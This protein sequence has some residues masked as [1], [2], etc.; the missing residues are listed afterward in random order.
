[1]QRR[2]FITLL[3]GAAVA[4]PFSARAQ[5]PAP[6]I[7]FLNSGEPTER[8]PFIAAFLRGLGEGGYLEGQTVAIEYRWAKGQYQ[9]LPALAAELVR[10][11]VAVIAATGG[12]GPGLAAKAATSTIPIVF[13]GGGDPVQL[14]LVESLGHPGGNATGIV[15]VSVELTSKRLE[16]LH[17]FVPATS[18]VGLLVDTDD[19]SGHTQLTELQH[20]ALALGLHLNVQNVRTDHDF[21]T[22][23]ANFVDQRIGALFIADTPLFVTWREKIVALAARHAIPTIYGFREFAAAGGLMSY[24]AELKD[25]YRLVGVYVSRILKG[26]KPS[27]LPVMQPTTFEFVINL[28]TAKALGLAVPLSLLGRADELIE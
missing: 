12:S 11:E 21:E 15:N 5:Q 4:W 16:L 22:A 10:R 6:V 26:E 18:I 8:A 20:A 24:G 13:S 27:S 28:R 7:G 2:A 25:S 23:F 17:E 9:Q 3:G 19:P 1:M 14:G